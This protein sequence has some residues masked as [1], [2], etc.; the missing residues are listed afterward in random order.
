MAVDAQAVT[1]A[2]D[3]YVNDVN[4]VFPVNRAYLFGSY[5]KHTSTKDSD[6]D[7]CFFSSS[8]DADDSIDI[9]AKLLGLARKY[10]PIANFEPHVFST[11]D[12]HTDN[13]FVK[14]VLRTGREIIR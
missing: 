1:Q 12:L 13:P 3:E 10:Y 14:E 11:A 8:L 5:A 4:E 9:V 2:I 7:V 6:V